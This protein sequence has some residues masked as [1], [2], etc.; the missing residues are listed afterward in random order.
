MTSILKIKPS[1]ED[2]ARLSPYLSGWNKLNDAIAK[3][4]FDIV[5]TETLLALEV[6]GKARKPI[7]ERL[8]GRLHTLELAARWAEIN[9]L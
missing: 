2:T 5:D 4:G 1:K 3:K 7:L 6:R 8:L 9:A